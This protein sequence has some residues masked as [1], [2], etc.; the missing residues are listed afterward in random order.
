MTKATF[1]K[2]TQ[3]QPV[4]PGQ[5][6]VIATHSSQPARELVAI[7]ENDGFKSGWLTA[8]G[9]TVQ[10]WRL[11]RP[12]RKSTSYTEREDR[13]LLKNNGKANARELSQAL[14]RSESSIKV[15]ACLLGVSLAVQG[16][17]YEHW[18]GTDERYVA[19]LTLAGFTP[20]EIGDKLER[21]RASV[22]SKIEAL[23][24]QGVLP[25]HGE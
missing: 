22:Y 17:I 20:Q 4:K 21:S 14:G 6:V 8:H 10:Q 19:E 13:I 12:Q 16:R 25:R 5:Y 1:I 7:W 23:R 24:R 18:N 15:R 11:E 9:W 3:S 2:I